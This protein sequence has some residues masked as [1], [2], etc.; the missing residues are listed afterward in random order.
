MKRMI[1]WFATNHVAA[2]LVMGFSVLAGL[3]AMTRIPIQIYPD[4]DFPFISITVPYL[5][6]APE[7]VASGVCNRIEERLQGISGIK[8][9]VAISD[10]GICAVELTLFLEADTAAVRNEVESA[11][12]AI[13]TFPAE[14]EKPVI[15][16]PTYT[17]VVLEVAVTGP[18]DERTLKEI[19]RRVRDDIKAL[20]GIT[21]VALTNSRPYEISV[22]ISEPSLLRN[23]LTF[24]HVAEA[25]RQGS[26]DLP[27]GTVKTDAGDVSLRTRGQAYRGEELENGW[28]SRPTA[29]A[30][31]F[32]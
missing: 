30:R 2:N 10:E 3:A 16:L 19:G 8:E 15:S 13:D 11:I 9:V 1:A 5:G 26:A 22:E 14:T 7:E 24:D 21:Q 18:T 32:F 20:P 4:V 12:N 6:A 25:L 27:G 29:A 23:N 31:A 17:S 28:W